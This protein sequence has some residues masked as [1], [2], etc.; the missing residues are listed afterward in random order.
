M[1]K[2]VL[3]GQ[4]FRIVDLSYQAE[5]DIKDQVRRLVA[6]FIAIDYPPHVVRAVLKKVQR[7]MKFKLPYME[8]LLRGG[9]ELARMWAIVD[10]A[11]NVMDRVAAE[12]FERMMEMMSDRQ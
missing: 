10:D 8:D 7:E 9:P 4:L 3:V 12:D 5:A 11:R 2:A 6:E 1:K